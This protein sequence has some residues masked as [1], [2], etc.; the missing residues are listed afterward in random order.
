MRTGTRTCVIYFKNGIGDFIVSLPAVKAIHEQ[1]HMVVLR[2]DNCVLDDLLTRMQWIDTDWQGYLAG[3][4]NTTDELCWINSWLSPEVEHIRTQ[5]AASF[6]RLPDFT[7]LNSPRVRT[8]H[9]RIFDVAKAL[10]AP[11]PLQHYATPELLPVDDQMKR[12]KA[13]HAGHKI[14]VV[15]LETQSE[16]M[17]S[18]A[19]AVSILNRIS[20]L[21]QGIVFIGLA[22]SEA[23]LTDQRCIWVCQRSLP[24]CLSI[25]SAADLFVGVDSCFLHAADLL[26]IP[27]IGIYSTGRG[28][29]MFRPRFTR[30]CLLVET[31]KTNQVADTLEEFCLS[32]GN[33]WGT[34]TS[35]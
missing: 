29:A 15:H 20:A 9:D 8:W 2:N 19:F 32:E 35:E 25:L 21:H 5:F 7:A 3:N 27:A 17:V 26:R 28:P 12:Y 24:Q 31:M 34:A 4:G 6:V 33:R 16:K 14:C 10:G 30:C 11:H 22:T 13:S 1:G 18:E 23:T